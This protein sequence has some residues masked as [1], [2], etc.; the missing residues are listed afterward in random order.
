MI[1]YFSATGNSRYV[2]ER[3]AK[4]LDDELLCLNDVLK[5]GVRGDWRSDKPYVIVCPI[6]AWRIPR[7]VEDCLRAA[8]LGGCRDIYF[9]VTCGQDAGAAASYIAPLCREKGLAF[10]GLAPIV[11][12]D[13]YLVLFPVPDKQETEQ[14]VQAA[15]PQ[16]DAAAARIRAR[17]ALDAVPAGAAGR[18]KSGPVNR[19][20][21]R[22]FV[23]HKGFYATD[24]CTGCGKCQSLCPMNAIRMQNGRPVWHE[25][26]THCMAC[27]H[28]CPVRAIEYKKGTRKKGR[29]HLD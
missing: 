20:F 22:F 27:I 29:Y 8:R 5:Q 26:C 28:R 24:A 15:G 21:Y 3:L 19:L 4:A 2:A 23:S 1:L 12:P 9:V 10:R 7:V 6:Y 14:K 16:I 17:Q 11:M 18:I 13:N 25:G